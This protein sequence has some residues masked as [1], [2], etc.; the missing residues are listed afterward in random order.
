MDTNGEHPLRELRDSLNMSI[1]DLA[2]ASGVSARTILRAEQGKALYPGSRKLL[3]QYFKRSPEELGLLPSWRSQKRA[4]ASDQV[5]LSGVDDMK[6]R[7]LLRV[8]SLAGSALLFSVDWEQVGNTLAHPARL[9]TKSLQYLEE[10]NQH[11]WQAYRAASQKSAI[12]N[13]VLSHLN[14]L[15][16]ALRDVQGASQR[17]YLCV[18]ASN[19]A[20]LCGEIFFD[21]SLYMDAAQ[22]Y[23][24]AANAAREANAYD[25]WACALVRHAFL[26]IYDRH[27]QE[28]LPLLQVAG[29]IAKRGDGTLVTKYWV[30]MVSAEAYAGLGALDDC[31]QAL[32]LAEGV[33]DVK[34]GMNGTWLRFDGERILEERGACL[35]K[36]GQ[37]GLAEPVLQEALLL[38][39]APTR[40][41]GMVLSDLA[42]AAV[43]HGEIERA[44]A[45]GSEVIQIAQL[46]SSGML[47]KS[48]SQLQM[49]LS[50]FAT[51][52]SVKDFSTQIQLLA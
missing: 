20:Q 17:Q 24:F 30:A 11:Y 49:Q 28:A 21:A 8:L 5:L 27:F 32:D 22:C 41:R 29:Q 18:L 42:L 2:A 13:D 35:V 51:N 3:C 16:Q 46:G 10:V 36:L 40:R 39:P 48:L 31:R 26:P 37:A 9:D 7:E 44:C 52:S 43:T 34:R 33:R 38:H 14:A 23:T 19:L 45:L 47:K 4:S 1:D 25:L 15:A 12:L 50:P 6:R